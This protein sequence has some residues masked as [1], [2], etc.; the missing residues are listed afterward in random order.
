MIKYQSNLLNFVIF[1]NILYLHLVN[2]T[3]GLFRT[4]PKVIANGR[5][6]LTKDAITPLFGCLEGKKKIYIYIS[7]SYIS[8]IYIKIYIYFFTYMYNKKKQL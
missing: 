8:Y 4:M 6:P 7:I 2:I 5:N 3:L 1:Y